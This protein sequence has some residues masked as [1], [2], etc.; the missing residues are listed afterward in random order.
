[1]DAIYAQMAEWQGYVLQVYLYRRCLWPNTKEDQKGPIYNP[2]TW[3]VG[4]YI[5]LSYNS[6]E[7]KEVITLNIVPFLIGSNPPANSL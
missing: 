2:D 5:R 3:M 4:T 7:A 1:M 6:D